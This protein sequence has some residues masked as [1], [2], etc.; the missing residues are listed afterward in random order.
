MR[1]VAGQWKGRR[2]RTPKGIQTRPTSDRVRESLF[3][4]LGPLTTHR[5]LDL[6]S[7]TG[8]IALEAVSRGASHAI[9]VE[10]HRRALVTLKENIHQLEAHSHIDVYPGDVNQFLLTKLYRE[11]SFNL[12]FADPPWAM[13]QAFIEAHQATLSQRVV[14][15]GYVV[16]ERAKR[17][18][19]PSEVSGLSGPDIRTY[20]D[21][22]L[23]IYRNEPSDP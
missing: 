23:A 19:S 15:G 14:P 16:L 18:G 5:V 20:G 4:I 2:L 11:H 7:G 10:H 21:T 22:L 6:F 3:N 12:I 13:A 9:C 17:D 8:A 1:I